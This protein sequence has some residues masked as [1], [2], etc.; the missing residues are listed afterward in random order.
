MCVD[1]DEAW[2][3]GQADGIDFLVAATRYLADPGDAAVLHCNITEEGRS[4]IPVH[5]GAAADHEDEFAGHVL[6]SFVDLPQCHTTR[7][8]PSICGSA[9]VALRSADKGRVCRTQSTSDW[10]IVSPGRPGITDMTSPASLPVHTLTA[11]I[12][13][14]RLSPVALVDECLTRIERLEPKLHA[15]VSV[16]AAN[17]RLAAEAA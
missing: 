10:L 7:C 1:V 6:G 2:G 15:F 8:D 4:A 17:A 14:R 9:A 11:N 12:A 5:D 3:N 16:N 13:A